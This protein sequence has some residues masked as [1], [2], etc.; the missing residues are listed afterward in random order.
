MLHTTQNPLLLLDVDGVLLPFRPKAGEY[1][2]FNRWQ[3]FSLKNGVR[4]RRLMKKF[5]VHWCTAWEH[6]ANIHIGPRHGLP[7]FPVCP[8]D[9]TKMLYNRNDP[10]WKLSSIIPY[11]RDKAFAFLDDDINEDSIMWAQQ[12]DVIVPTRFEKV[13]PIIGLTDEH[14][15]SLLEWAE[16]ISLNPAA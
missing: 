16:E 2:D 4:V 14:V 10:H 11:V 5:S 8:L 6:D 9:R 1:K 13:D 15:E 7:H 12:R 3:G